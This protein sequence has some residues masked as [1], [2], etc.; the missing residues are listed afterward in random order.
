MKPDSSGSNT[1][2]HG[3]KEISAY[4][5]RSVR[6]LQRWT[7]EFGFPVHNIAHTRRSPVCAYPHEIDTWLE[8]RP[9]N[10]IESRE[11]LLQR[12]EQLEAEL[13]RLREAQQA[14]S[15]AA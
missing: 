10:A 1:V 12:I 9:N 2:L 14:D 8:Q 3:W 4:S 7:R 15:A 5:R 11:Q 13:K 6:T